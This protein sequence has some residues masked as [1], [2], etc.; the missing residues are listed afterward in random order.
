M[1]FERE[2]YAIF[3]GVLAGFLHR[4]DGLLAGGILVIALLDAA[5]EDANRLATQQ[6]RVFDPA[7]DRIEFLLE[8]VGALDAKVVAD[9]GPA[10][11]ES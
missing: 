1:V 4:F 8:C 11:V 3:A 5:S 6:R 2:V 7:L 9:G 10:Y